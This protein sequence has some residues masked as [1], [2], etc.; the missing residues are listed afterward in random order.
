MAGVAGKRAPGAELEMTPVVLTTGRL[1]LDQPAPGDRDVMT[2]QC[3]DPLFESML[4]TP[5]PYETHHADSFIGETVPRGWADDTEYTWAIRLDGAFTGI[6]GYRVPGDDIGFWIGRLYRGRGYMTEAVT[7]VADWLFS[8][9]RDRVV[10]ECIAGNTASASVARKC[11]FTFTGAR[12]ALVADR[13]GG[14]APAWHGV[15]GSED[16]RMPKHGWPPL[17]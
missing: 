5:W 16:D 9:G 14:Y 8:I 13:N 10:W 1:T 11:G 2:T 3:Q 15:L 6:V 17:S 4:T 7:A 12:P